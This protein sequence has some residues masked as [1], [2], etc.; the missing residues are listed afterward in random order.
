[1][2]KGLLAAGIT[3]GVAAVF[4]EHLAFAFFGGVL[5]LIVGVYPGIAM[6]NPE[7]GSPVLQWVIAV[8]ILG[9]G[10]LGLWHSAL[11]LSAAF[12]LHGLWSFLKGFTAL[13]DGVPEGYPAFSLSFDLVLA[14]FVAYMWATSVQS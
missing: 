13:G 3:L 14:A 10:L 1:L 6:A 11:L 2:L 9:L 4:P 8:G 7:V 12:L 5:G